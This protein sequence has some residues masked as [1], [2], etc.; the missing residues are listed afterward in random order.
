MEDRAAIWAYAAP[1]VGSWF[2]YIP[3]WSILPAF[4][5]KYGGLPLA[6]VATCL[7][8]IRLFDGFTDTTIGYLADWHRSH[9]G[10]R[11]P[12]TAIGGLGSIVICFFLF[13]PPHP[14]TSTYYL[15]WSFAYFLAYTISEIPHL[16]WASELTADYQ[17]RSAVYAV[18]TVTTRI[19][20]LSFYALPLLPLFGT[21]DYAPKVMHDAVYF[22]GVMT[23]MGVAVALAKAPAGA[24][25]NLLR[26]DS[27]RLLFGS[28]IHNKPLL[29]Y[30]GAFA[31]GGVYC[32]MWYGLLYL[33]LDNYLALASKVPLILFVA[34]LAAALSTPVWLKLIRY[35][36]KATSWALCAALFLLQLIG[37]LFVAPKTS[38][39]VMLLLVTIANMSFSC[40]DV[41]GLS[42]L[43]DIVD[44]GKLRFNKD[45]GAFYFAVNILVFKVTLGLGSAASLAIAASFGYSATSAANST[46]AID[47]L[48]LGFIIVP[49]CFAAV[50]LLMMRKAPI[51]RRKHSIIQRRLEVKLARASRA[52]ETG[53]ITGTSDIQRVLIN[54]AQLSRNVEPLNG[55][56]L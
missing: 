42:L 21:A 27:L 23:L 29:L 33:Y 34:T 50:A 40:N 1:T 19:G 2:Y 46:A 26:S 4:Y 17:K 5:A 56:F 30:F 18:R 24:P 13:N 3:M 47:G 12:W 43:G 53:R 35:T 15:T 16:A 54:D 41:A 52:V 25:A 48:K 37:T 20:I 51:D 14:A 9:G 31:C 55:G 10:T 39:W 28:L 44:Y 45:R 7:L 6:T 49:A 38:W 32:G 22:G 11:K 8:L 36:G